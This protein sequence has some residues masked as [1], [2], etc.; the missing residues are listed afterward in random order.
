MTDDLRR[1]VAEVEREMRRAAERTEAAMYPD[2][3]N[4]PPLRE[5]VDRLRDALEAG[6][7]RRGDTVS[8][9]GA[10]EDPI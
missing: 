9:Y 4:R 7:P 3:I 1:V 8:T 6:Q 10:Y 2:E 5:W